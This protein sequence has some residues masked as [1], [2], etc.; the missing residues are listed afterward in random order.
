VARLRLGQTDSA[1][2]L[3]AASIRV[4]SE[5]KAYYLHHSLFSPLWNDPRFQALL[6]DTLPSS[7]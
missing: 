7:R 2:A 4:A 5:E 3:I 6:R 1:L